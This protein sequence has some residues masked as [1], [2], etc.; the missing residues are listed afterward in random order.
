MSR[1][2]DREKIV[3]KMIERGELV[4]PTQEV[5]AIIASR[6]KRLRSF[7]KKTK[8]NKKRKKFPTTFTDLVKSASSSQRRRFWSIYEDEQRRRRTLDTLG[9]YDDKL[10]L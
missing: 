1:T 4:E 7:R 3:S 6:V 5:D 9:C 10:G 2:S 8:T